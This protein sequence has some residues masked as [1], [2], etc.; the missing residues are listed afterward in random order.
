MIKGLWIVTCTFPISDSG[1]KIISNK[2]PNIVNASLL[3][4]KKTQQT[5]NI[6]NDGTGK[7]SINGS[8]IHFWCN[9]EIRAH[10][11]IQSPHNLAASIQMTPVIQ[12]RIIMLWK[13]HFMWWWYSQHRICI[14]KHY[15]NHQIGCFYW[16]RFPK[17]SSDFMICIS[18]YITMGCDHSTM[19]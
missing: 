7:P 14:S 9:C 19:T 1:K 10:I 3:L 8:N 18:N 12:A 17:T 16:Q 2:Q 11:C 6:E 4:K 13:V 5:R 15:F